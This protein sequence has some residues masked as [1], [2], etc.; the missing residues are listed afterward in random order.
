MDIENKC[1]AIHISKLPFCFLQTVPGFRLEMHVSSRMLWKKKESLTREMPAEGK[2]LVYRLLYLTVG[3]FRGGGDK[4]KQKSNSE[5][6]APPSP[7]LDFMAMR[8]KDTLSKLRI[9]VFKAVVLVKPPHFNCLSGM[10]DENPS[11]GCRGIFLYN[12]C[13]SKECSKASCEVGV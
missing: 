8:L 10:Y 3:Y 9:S 13:K 12:S 1:I 11:Q 5:N 4:N 2:S 6:Q 7:S